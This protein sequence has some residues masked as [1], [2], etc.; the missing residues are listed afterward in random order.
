MAHDIRILGADGIATA[1]EWARREGWNPGLR[2]AEA[3]AAADPQGFQGLYAA[4]QM[5]ATI[6]LV[7]YGLE[8]AFLGFYICEPSFRGKGLG[9]ALWN[10]ALERCEA[11]TIGL[12]GVTAQQANYRTSGFVLAHENIRFGGLK[13][14]GY[15]QLDPALAQ[16]S[17][18][19]AAEISRFEQRHGL[20]P[21]E[22]R[23]FLSA[24]LGHHALVL[25]RN[26]EVEGYGVIRPCHEGWKIG[27]LF[28]TR[29]EEAETILRG[30]LTFMPEGMMF[31]D[32][33]GTHAAARELATSLKLQPMFETARMYRGPAPQ[34]ATEKIF[35][36]TS[37][38]LG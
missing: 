38:E 5:A 34:L 8:F 30:L 9:L 4:G 13:P 36:I 31:L 27:P 10:H 21:A 18:A 28:A 32:V 7:S 26:G 17:P 11:R 16:L 14:A 23:A 12:D 19:D 1:V 20:F 25:R 24:W 2:D 37:F 29:I 6:S 22:R 3:F 15:A 35:G 33:P